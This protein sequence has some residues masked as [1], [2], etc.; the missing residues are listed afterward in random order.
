MSHRRAGRRGRIV[1]DELGEVRDDE[2]MKKSL[3]KILIFRTTALPR[4]LPLPN[5]Q[6]SL[7]MAKTSYLP[8]VTGQQMRCFHCTLDL[9]PIQL[10]FCQC[11]QIRLI[12][13]RPPQKFHL[14][15]GP[16]LA[17]SGGVESGIVQMEI[18]A[19]VE[20]SVHGFDAVG[21]EDHDALVILELTEEDYKVR[22]QY[23]FIYPLTTGRNLSNK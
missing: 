5:L 4:P 20:C 11:I 2:R 7:N 15:V 10:M 9:P 22:N 17:A 3:E 14:E 16:D 23:S 6:H 12:N 1:R 18:D 21:C 8:L 19:R 13:R